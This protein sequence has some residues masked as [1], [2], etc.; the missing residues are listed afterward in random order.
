[1]PEVT[2][3]GGPFDGK[4][5]GWSGGDT[6]RL[7]EPPSYVAISAKAPLHELTTKIQYVEYRQSLNN[8]NIFVYQP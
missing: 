4:K 1:M 8:R 3:Y 5:V 7:S 2:L 6:I